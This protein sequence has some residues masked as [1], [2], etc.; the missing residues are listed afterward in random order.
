M[1]LADV[2]SS[3]AHGFIGPQPSKQL[4]V[5]KSI[6]SRWWYSRM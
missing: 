4:L 5:P 3:V 1:T 2:V 6:S